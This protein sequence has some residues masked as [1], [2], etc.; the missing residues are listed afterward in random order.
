[1]P[2]E[3]S[4]SELEIIVEAFQKHGVE[5]ILIGGQAEWLHGSPRATF[6]YDFCY[7]RSPENCRRL[8]E[9][10]RQFEPTLRGAPADLPFRV[11]G[12]T[13]EAGCNFTFSTNVG[14]LDLLGYV[15]PFGGLETLINTAETYE[16]GGMRI[17]A[18]SVDDLIRIKR[19]LNRPKD[20]ESLMQLL[21]IK[22]VREEGG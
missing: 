22:Q 20:R 10:L 2:S 4:K 14:S 5:F 17:K 13:I 3:S 12:A 16:L 6:D 8:A 21:A 15:E 1:M 19:H 7:G 11:D 9:A 18:I